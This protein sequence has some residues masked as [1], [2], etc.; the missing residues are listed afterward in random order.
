MG[1]KRWLPPLNALRAFEAAARH[2]SFTR[3]AEEL[4][5]TQTA[6]S[7][8]I[9]TLESRLGLK[10]FDRHGPAIALTEAAKAYLPSVRSAFDELYD[11]TEY[12]VGPNS[13]NTLTVNTLTTFASKWLVPR[14]G[15]FQDRHPEISVRIT[16]STAIV[17]FERDDVD[18]AIRYG[19]GVWPGLRADHLMREDLFPVCSPKL[20]YGAH[21]LRTPEDLR[22][23]T[24]LHVAGFR[25]DW[26]VWLTAAGIDS[27]DPSSGL[28]F[29]LALNALQAASD[30][31]GVAL[32]R[33]AFVQDDLATGRLIAPFD[34]LLPIEG[35]Y[36]IVAP[37][38]TADRPKI[39][40]FRD[41]LTN[42][43][44]AT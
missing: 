26:Q 39:K 32:G 20:L 1:M 28:R 33:T 16:T 36:Y 9:K 11:A 13:E 23:H 19:R 27:I 22:H 31:M 25:E 15:G 42:S 18:V 10:L 37:E 3:A 44:A 34:M 8:Q 30:G 40:A 43:M 2:R 41:W 38:R 17:D 29:D 35:A 14:L 6:V 12:L 7:H 4:N 24:L 5:V 21:P